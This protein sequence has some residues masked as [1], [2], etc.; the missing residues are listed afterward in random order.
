[1]EKIDFVIPWVDGNDLQWRAEKD[2]Y[3]HILFPAKLFSDQSAAKSS[4]N[5]DCRYRELGLLKYW[6]RSVE[7]F[8]P[9]VNK[10]YFITCG[11]KPDWLNPSHPKLVLVDH[12]DYIPESYL[13]T[14]N[15]ITI[16]LNLHRIEGLSEHFVYF[17]DDVFLLQ[18]IRPELFFH[19]GNPILLSSLKYPD[20]LGIN[21]W[22]HQVFNDYCLVNKYHDIGKTI[23]ENRKK[24]FNVGVLGLNRALRNYMCYLVN[25]SLPVGNYEHLATPNLKSTVSEIWEKCYKELDHASS[26]KFRSDEQVNQWLFCAWNQARGTFFPSRPD[27]RGR[28]VQIS[29][30]YID[31]ICWII[32]NQSMP[33]VCLNDTNLNTDPEGCAELIRKAFDQILPRK[34]SFELEI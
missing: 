32:Q 17:N 18:P 16:E 14:F 27:E 15:S 13:P 22:S 6:F 24:W 21:C 3:E 20:Y 12:R 1:M 2:K 29:P 19:E 25:K 9:W 31:W 4:A 30:K 8:A 5:A 26:F 10:I 28:R 34:S 11:Q 7:R 23:W 33:Q